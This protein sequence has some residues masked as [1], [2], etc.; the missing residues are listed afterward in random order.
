[1][2]IRLQNYN[3]ASPP[4]RRFCT[5]VEA[6][7]R[8]AVGAAL[9]LVETPYQDAGR[10]LRVETPDGLIGAVVAKLPFEKQEE[11]NEAP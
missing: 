1:M 10:R 3:L 6:A 8:G 9:A 11:E 2:L 4:T 5:H 7:I